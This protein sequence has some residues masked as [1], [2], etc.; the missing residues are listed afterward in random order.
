MTDRKNLLGARWTPEQDTWLTV[1]RNPINGGKPASYDDLAVTFN[2]QFGTS[3]TSHGLM[4]RF[5]YLTTKKETEERSSRAKKAAQSRAPR[6]GDWSVAELQRLISYRE[7]GTYTSEEIAAKLTEEFGYKRTS[8]TI[9]AEAHRL[10]SHPELLRQ[11]QGHKETLTSTRAGLVEELNK[12]HHATVAPVLRDRSDFVYTLMVQQAKQLV[13]FDSIGKYRAMTVEDVLKLGDAERAEIQAVLS[14][15]SQGKG[16]DGIVLL[17]MPEYG[18]A[19]GEVELVMPLYATSSFLT[20]PVKNLRSALH[21]VTLASLVTKDSGMELVSATP[22][23]WKELVSYHFIL[24]KQPDYGVLGDKITGQ[25]ASEY[26]QRVSI[27]R[28]M[29]L[30]ER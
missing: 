26:K 25:L 14:N 30:I 29:P 11:V 28:D 10:R 12:Y 22:S 21:D 7:A 9:R 13:E 20:K 2:A 4:Q 5:S 17:A 19:Q 23:S 1:Q 24:K 16:L 6:K 8:S 3:R 27:F 15:P 18:R